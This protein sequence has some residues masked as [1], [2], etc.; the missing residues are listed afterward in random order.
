MIA[1][2]PTPIVE[3]VPINRIRDGVRVEDDVCLRL[4][5]AHGT[6]PVRLG[7]H[8]YWN[9]RDW[10]ESTWYEVVEGDL[11]SDGR[12]ITLVREPDYAAQQEDDSAEYQVL[13]KADGSGQCD[14]RGYYAGEKIGHL[15][16]HLAVLSWLIRE[17]HLPRRSV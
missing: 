13:V 3:L 14:C 15:C 6:L 5:Y 7:I 11:V 9:G 17:G 4:D 16:K 8:S 10:K 1:D 12:L 2:I